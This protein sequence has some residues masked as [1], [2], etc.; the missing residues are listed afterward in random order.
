VLPENI[1]S[2]CP[3]EMHS[4]LARYLAGEISG[5]L[6]LMHFVVA[7]RQAEALAAT[8]ESL[9]SLKPGCKEISD[10]VRLSQV[11]A[12]DLTRVA[13]IVQRG[14]MDL[15]S[16]VDD[17]VAF[18]A[19]Q[20][21]KAVATAPEASVALYSLG[22]TEILDRATS[23]I[24]ARL[25][26][27]KLLAPECVVLDLGCGIGR[28]ERALAPH[29][30]KVIGID[31]SPGM[32]AEARRRC[33]DLTN[34]VLNVCDGRDLAS[35]DDRSLDLVLA[36]DSFPYLVAADPALAARH[37]SDAARLLRPGGALL[38][39]NFSYRGNS[40]VDRSDVARLASEYRFVL[41]RAGTRDFAL[42]DGVTFL[43]RK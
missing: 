2:S 12:D 3:P 37:V 40:D 42:W 5:E 1:G 20:F 6:A 19:N 26:E 30:G 36:V 14:L 38:I 41:E 24:L 23:E 35:F 25:T 9:A 34:V 39:L 43:L 18:I 21:D 16:A 13:C 11:H 8:L 22:S 10:L 32:I 31:V 29:V 7:L 15:P 27:W 33:S 28:F 17:G 4:A